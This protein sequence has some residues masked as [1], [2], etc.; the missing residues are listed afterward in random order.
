MEGR[1]GRVSELKGQNSGYGLA[2]E[3]D[4]I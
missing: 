3:A 4:I 2:V 1:E